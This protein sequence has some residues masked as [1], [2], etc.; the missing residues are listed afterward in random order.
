MEYYAR[1]AKGKNELLIDHLNKTSKLCEEY[2]SVFDMPVTGR[3]LGRLHDIGKRTQK[4]QDVLFKDKVKVNHAIVAGSEL[5]R[6]FN[7]HWPYIAHIIASHHYGLHKDWNYCPDFSNP[8]SLIDIEQK[9]NAL[10]SKSE[11][12]DIQKWA[13]DN[14]IQLTKQEAFAMYNEFKRMKG[15]TNNE[16]MFINRML[17]SCLVDADYSASA[18][19]ENPDYLIEYNGKELDPELMLKRLDDYRADLISKSTSNSELNAL[20]NEVFDSCGKAGVSSFGNYTLTAPTGTAK[21]LAML[22]FALENAK[23][24]NKQRIIIVL[25]YLSIIE[26]SARIYKDI[27]GDD[28]VLEDDSQT[29][30]T[31]K[32][33][34]LSE[35]WSAPI[36]VTTSVNLFETLFK[37]S[38]SDL[39]KLHNIANSVIVFDESQTIP[40][41]ILDSTLE[42]IKTLNQKFN[43]TT[44]F[45]TATPPSFNHRKHINWE[46]Q[47]VINNPQDM[48]DRYSKIKNLTVDWKIDKVY[49]NEELYQLMKNKDSYLVI[50]NLKRHANSFY[51]KLRNELPRSEQEGLF[52]ISTNLCSTHRTEVLEKIKKRLAAGLPTKVVSTQCLEA[53]VDLDFQYVYRAMGPATSIAQAAGRCSRNALFPGVLTIFMPEGTKL[54]P[55]NTY[56]NQTLQLQS[57]ICSKG[58]FDINSLVDIDRYYQMVFNTHGLDADNRNLTE[59]INRF[60]YEDVNKE[61]RL[62]KNQGATII[63]PFLGQEDFYNQVKQELIKNDFCISKSMMSKLQKITVTSYDKKSVETLCQELSFRIKEDKVPCNW[64]LLDDSL[65]YYDN[66]MG[67][68]FSSENN[69]I[70]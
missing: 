34:L 2:T 3:V 67:L 36:I 7:K 1:K 44:L 42:V 50:F 61:Y 13:E 48:F 15:M 21:T 57:L 33:R 58:T 59:A 28:V 38:G 5:H 47:E 39:R 29:Q 8:I 4:F 20:R 53:G 17:F 70:F 64:Y 45:S 65:G 9:E 43:V 46:A 55:D 60:S 68:D 49:G 22:K 32:S 23:Y 14:N 10:S 30:Y 41:E 56:K 51:N 18:S 40:N 37:R 31:E 52:Y 54:Y 27:C 12:E 16:N 24:N 26:Q 62:I 63:V 35:R 66:E 19:F 11:F 25:P 6:H 69:F